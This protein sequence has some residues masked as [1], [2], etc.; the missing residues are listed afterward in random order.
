M[1]IYSEASDSTLLILLVLEEDLDSMWSMK[2]FESGIVDQAI[3]VAAGKFVP[4]QI[5]IMQNIF[6]PIWA[7]QKTYAKFKA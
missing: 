3:H 1:H 6:F 5:N 7:N 2:V 4:T